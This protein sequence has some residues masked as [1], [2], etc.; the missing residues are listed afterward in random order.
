MPM[1]SAMQSILSRRP[2]AKVV[3]RHQVVARDTETNTGAV[4]FF[5]KKQH[6]NGDSGLLV[7]G[8]YLV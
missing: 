6:H 1:E 3:G 2:L 4:H 8:R 5:H 7:T